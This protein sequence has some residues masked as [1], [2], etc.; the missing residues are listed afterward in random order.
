MLKNNYNYTKIIRYA[1]LLKI[2]YYYASYFALKVSAVLYS[3]YL[4]IKIIILTTLSCN[5]FI[6]CGG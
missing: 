1:T 6:M 4:V 2:Y 5:C 3:H